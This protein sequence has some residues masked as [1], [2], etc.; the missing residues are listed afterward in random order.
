MKKQ[1]QNQGGFG[2][3]SLVLGIMGLIIFPIFFSTLAIIF[4]AIGMGKNQKYSKEGFTLGIF[5]LVLW[6]II[7]IFFASMVLS[8]F[9]PF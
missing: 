2:T 1:E 7:L 6:M 8:I 9:S 4:G 5:G 3:A